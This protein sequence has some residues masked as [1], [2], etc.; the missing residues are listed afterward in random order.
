MK[1]NKW[2]KSLPSN[3]KSPVLR[4]PLNQNGRDFV[5]G[6]IHGHFELFEQLLERVNFDDSCDR[7]LSVGDAI[8]RGPESDRNMEY[9][10][11]HWFYSVLG[12]HEAM[13][14]GSMKR[15]YGLYELWMH[16]GGEWSEMVSEPELLEMAK[17]Y[18]TLPQVIDVETNHGHVGVVHADVPP[19]LPWMEFLKLLEANKLPE[20]DMKILLWSRETYKKLRMLQEYP[21]AMQETQIADVHRVFVGHSIVKTPACYG[22]VMFIDT[23]AYT[24]GKLSAVDITNDEVI[25]VDSGTES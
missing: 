22:N 25:I 4:L 3:K 9:Y 2:S 12:N 6:D 7:I 1:Q 11:K 15:V 24:T 21:G 13:L 10:E 5:V 23:G 19:N 8:D 16:N 20:R 17:F 14:I 18:E